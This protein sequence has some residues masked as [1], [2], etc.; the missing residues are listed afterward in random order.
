M[1]DQNEPVVA[2][3]VEDLVG[4]TIKEAT[5]II[6]RVMNPAGN[7]VTTIRETEI[8]GEGMM[9]T[10]DFRDDRVNVATANGVITK[11]MNCG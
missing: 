11:I 1:S 2:M 10:M 7:I 8:D 9:V 5:E 6:D 3:K 4:K